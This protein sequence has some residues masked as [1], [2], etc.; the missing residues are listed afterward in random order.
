[1]IQLNQIVLQFQSIDLIDMK[2]EFYGVFI[3]FNSII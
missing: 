2:D 1:M 3:K